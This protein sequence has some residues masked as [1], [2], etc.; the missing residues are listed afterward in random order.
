MSSHASGNAAPVSPAAPPL[1][2]VPVIILGCGNVAQSLL[3]QIRIAADYHASRHGV[4]FDVLAMADSS[5]I[6]L[7]RP[8]GTAPPA[9][10]P[11]DIEKII[12][13]KVTALIHARW[14]AQT[15]DARE[16]LISMLSSLCAPTAGAEEKPVESLSR[17]CQHRRAAGGWRDF[18]HSL[19]CRGRFRSE[20]HGAVAAAGTGARWSSCHGE[21]KTHGRPTAHVGSDASAAPAHKTQ[22]REHGGSRY[23][24]AQ[25]TWSKMDRGGM[26]LMLSSHACS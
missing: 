20:W 9:L 16:L 24:S 5:G 3:T 18:P 11:K 12:K 22:I 4:R 23:E 13:L 21:Q 10:T 25:Q 26:C 8:S 17:Q 2:R 19:H 15:S 7:A 6:V 14:G 1:H